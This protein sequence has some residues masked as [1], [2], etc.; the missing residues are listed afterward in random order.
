MR[1]P[2]SGTDKKAAR[3]ERKLNLIREDIIGNF[4]PERRPFFFSNT[5]KTT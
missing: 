5:S 2:R 4:V 3:K 1:I